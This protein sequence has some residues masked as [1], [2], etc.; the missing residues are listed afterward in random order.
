VTGFRLEDVVSDGPTEIRGEHAWTWVEVPV[1]GVGWVV[2]DPA[3]AEQ[4]AIEEDDQETAEQEEQEEQQVV[5]E[6]R[7]VVGV[8]PTEVIG[9]APPPEPISPWVIAGLIVGGM[10]ATLLLLMLLAAGRRLVRRRRRLRGEARERLLGAW[11]EAID[12]L[13]DV[14]HRDVESL[15]AQE[16]VDLVGQ[17]APALAKPLPWFAEAANRAVFSSRLISDDEAARWWKLT[18]RLRVAMRRNAPLRRRLVAML[19]PAPSA[20]ARAGRPPATDAASTGP[21]VASEA[22]T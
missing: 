17:R 10:L 4:E 11:H 6:D 12:I 13:Y 19:L 16:F 8:D 7:A 5:E 2:V 9:R 1:Q 20:L 14:G 22:T 18:R 3:P 21:H 15:S